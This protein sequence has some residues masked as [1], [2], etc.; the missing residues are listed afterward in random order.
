M[1]IYYLKSE[2]QLSKTLLVMVRSGK[3]TS[4]FMPL[5]HLSERILEKKRKNADSVSLPAGMD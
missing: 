1:N 5:G 3:V 4:P 2:K